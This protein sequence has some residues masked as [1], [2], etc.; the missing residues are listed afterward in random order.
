MKKI[1]FIFFIILLS[2]VIV[3][4]DINERLGPGLPPMNPKSYIQGFYELNEMRVFPMSGYRVNK[5]NNTINLGEWRFEAPKVYEISD[6][7][8]ISVTIRSEEIGKGLISWEKGGSYTDYYYELVEKIGDTSYNSRLMS[9]L[10][11]RGIISIADT[12]QAVTITCNRQIDENH[13]AGSS[14]NDIFSVY[15]EDPYAIVKNGYK[16]LT[17][18]NYYSLEGLPDKF[19][20]SLFGA[21]LSSVDFTTKLYMGIEWGLVLETAPQNTG[22]YIFTVSITNKAGKTIEKTANP[23]KIKGLE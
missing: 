8:G 5:E 6:G 13:P 7:I 10:S 3:R 4:C 15:F 12:L 20:H 19:P 9:G 11:S 14:L 21:R 18:E 22:E 16:S 23:I 1:L 17:G 2:M